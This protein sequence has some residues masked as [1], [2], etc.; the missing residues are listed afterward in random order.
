M[1]TD[2]SASIALLRAGEPPQDDTLLE[3][4]SV[5][6]DFITDF[7]NEKYLKE[8]IFEGG[9]K[10][11]FVTGGRGSGK[12]HFV[13]L[14]T[15]QA[16][17]QNYI[18]V[19]FSANQVWIHDFKEIY[20]QIINSVDILDL[21]SKCCEKIIE[22]LGFGDEQM[23][24]DISFV[25][26]L[27][28][29]SL[30]DALT[31]RE[32]RT[33]LSKMFLKNTLID[34]NFGY[35]CSLIT[36]G[37]LGYPLLEEHNRE[38][39][40]QWLSGDKTAALSSLRRLGLSPCRI[41]KYNARHM[42]RSLIEVIKLAG[43]SGLVVT[44][45][46]LEILINKDSLEDIRYTK[47]KR[48]DSYESIR[49]LVDEIDS[50]KNVMFLFAFDRKLI[51]NEAMGLKSYQALWMRIQNEVVSGKLNRFT[52][53]LDMDILSKQ[54]YTPQ[55]VLKMSESLSDIMNLADSKVH[56]I[57]E[58]FAQELVS[59][60]QFASVS[61]PLQVNIATLGGKLDD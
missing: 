39:L 43:Y 58:I 11:K 31:K 23:P 57:D 3:K 52:D 32:I 15:L 20:V 55:S 33:L 51:E 38:L 4:L 5:G 40:M 41:T 48:E 2:I 9:S 19:N 29:V 42:L 35:A 27:S 12:T 10:I 36:G 61:L 26:Y 7:W 47:L 13:Q 46:D 49:E 16:K 21:L 8:Y 53:I 60:S 54:I 22:E 14:F 45:D 28:S 44:I 30:L 24:T 37:I 18:T 56:A 34:N 59:H 25:D 17:K 50:L 6:M 1:D